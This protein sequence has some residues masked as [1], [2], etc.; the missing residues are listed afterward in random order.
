MILSVN[1]SKEE[2]IVSI[3]KE[4]NILVLSKLEMLKF[5]NLFYQTLKLKKKEI[6]ISIGNKNLDYKNTILLSFCDYTEILENLV[7]KK[8]SMFYEFLISNIQDSIDLDNDILLYD[9]SNIVQ[10]TLE[11]SELNINFE[12]E[13]NIEKVILDFV[14][15]DLKYEIKD[16]VNILNQLLTKFIEK[17]T[18]KNIVVFYDSELFD[19]PFSSFD[20]CYSFDISN[21]KIIKTYNLICDNN[22]NEFEYKLLKNKLENIW[23]IEFLEEEIINYINEYFVKRA[24]RIPLIATTEQEYLTYILM[25]KIYENNNQIK[26]NNFQ[27]RDNVKSFLEH[28]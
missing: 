23:P 4:N 8:G 13:E 9:I 7:F 27:L 21:N 11:S 2:K 24:L 14:Q 10:N 3:A 20:N 5:F 17:N 19:F 25:D 26:Y 22:I 12:M 6:K 15:F 1:D 18:T 28:I 16:L